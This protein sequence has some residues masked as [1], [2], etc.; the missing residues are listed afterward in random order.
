MDVD[1]FVVCFWYYID[2]IVEIGCR[3]VDNLG[4]FILYDIGCIVMFGGYVGDKM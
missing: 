4:F 2:I 3:C 1:L